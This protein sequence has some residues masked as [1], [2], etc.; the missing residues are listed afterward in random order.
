MYLAYGVVTY[1]NED[2]GRFAIGN[3]AYKVNSDTKLYDA[4]GDIA[5]I[6]ISALLK[7]I[8]KKE[9]TEITLDSNGVVTSLRLVG[10]EAELKELFWNKEKVTTIN[11]S[12]DV[13]VPYSVK[14]VPTVTANATEKGAKVEVTQATKLDGTTAEKT[15]TIKVTSEDGKVNKTYTVVFTQSA[16]SEDVTLKA[17]TVGGTSYVVATEIEVTLPKDSTEPLEVKAT[18]TDANAKVEITA[19]KDVKSDVKADRTTT[20]KVT[21]EDG[22]TTETYNVVFKLAE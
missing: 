10:T 19:A 9:V 1:I 5:E 4:N 7:A 8:D 12:N 2:D 14:S 18:A 13:S 20:I 3:D 22:K 6:G 11:S 15:A 21:A 17:I 16:A